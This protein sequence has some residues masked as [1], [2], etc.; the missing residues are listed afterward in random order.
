MKPGM[1]GDLRP[2]A[3]FLPKIPKNSGGGVGARVVECFFPL[4][5]C[6]CISDV[7]FDYVFCLV[8]VLLQ[9]VLLVFV[10]DSSG[11]ME[12]E[13]VDIRIGWLDL[14]ELFSLS[15]CLPGP[16]P[17]PLYN[18]PYFVY[19]NIVLSE[20]K[21]RGRNRLSCLGKSQI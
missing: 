8:L 7:Q 11:P 20:R 4:L 15:I 5:L 6:I 18:I 10:G 17:F 13:A 19:Y 16:H 12:K 3:F 9:S 2:T 21:K 14:I 1:S